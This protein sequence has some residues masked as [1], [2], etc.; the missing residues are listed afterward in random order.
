MSG[1]ELQDCL[2]SDV[3]ISVSSVL[4]LCF[5][6]DVLPTVLLIVSFL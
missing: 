6:N 1:F 2:V 4:V 3:I 5:K